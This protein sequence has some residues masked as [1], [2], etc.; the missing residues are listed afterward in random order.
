MKA[1]ELEV[2]E[3]VKEIKSHKI[4]KKVA[5]TEIYLKNGRVV[6]AGSEK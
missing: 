1:K 3:E 4:N 5:P 6:K 2:K